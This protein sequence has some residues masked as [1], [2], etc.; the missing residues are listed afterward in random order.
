MPRKPL[1]D[2]LLAHSVDMLALYEKQRKLTKEMLH[3]YECRISTMQEFIRANFTG[4]EQAFK[5]LAPIVGKGTGTKRPFYNDGFL[6]VKRTKT[7]VKQAQLWRE[8]H[9]QEGKAD[10]VPALQ[11]GALSDQ[12]RE[13]PAAPVQAG[14]TLSDVESEGGNTD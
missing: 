13:V 7:V 12:A 9:E 8:A 11:D 6:D 4:D 3:A 10:P 5:I 1:H 2:E 14:A